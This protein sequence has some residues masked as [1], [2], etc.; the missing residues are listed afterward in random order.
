MSRLKLLGNEKVLD[1]TWR[2]PY[3]LTESIA[4]QMKVKYLTTILFITIASLVAFAGVIKENSLSASSDGTNILV[5]WLSEDESNVLRYEIER[6]AGANGQFFMITQFAPR[7]NNSA[8]DYLDQSAFRTTEGIYRYQVKVIFGNG[9]PAII[10]GP[11][12]VSHNPS[13]VRRTWG[14]IKAMFR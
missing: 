11:I 8:Y 3:I 7:G 9:D 5:R 1:I 6:K 4:S 13:S 14:S 12:T 10:Y 2:W